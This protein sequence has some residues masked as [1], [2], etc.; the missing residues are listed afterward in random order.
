MFGPPVCFSCGWPTGQIA[1]LF[2]HIRTQRAKKLLKDMG[3]VPEK[4]AFNYELT[5][6]NSDVLE[7]LAVPHACCRVCVTTTMTWKDH[8]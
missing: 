4:A 7:K 2:K 5:Q 6:D 1:V 3:T 8:N